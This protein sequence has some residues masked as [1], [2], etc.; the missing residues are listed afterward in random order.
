M[1]LYDFVYILAVILLFPFWGKYFLKK[2]Y[3][4]LLKHRL[5][6]DIESSQKKRIWVH[7]VSVGEVKSL[8]NFL[9]EVKKKYPGDDIVLSVTTPSGYAVARE[10]YVSLGILVINSPLD[11]SFT[12]RRFLKKINPRILVLNELEIWPNWIAVT[13]KKKVPIILINGRMSEIAFKRY[14]RVNFFLKRFFKRIDRF[15]VQAEI[16]K[17]RFSQLNI[18]LGKIKICGNIKA[19]E[20]VKGLERMPGEKNIFAELGIKRPDRSRKKILAVASSH[21][22]DEQLLVPLLPSL[23]KSFFVIIVPRHLDRVPNIEAHLAR[24]GVEPVTWSKRS[25]PGTGIGA[26][27]DKPPPISTNQSRVMIFDRMGYLFQ[28]LKISDLVFMGGTMERKI[29][30]HNL[31]EPAVLGK[32]I[33]GGP[34]FNNFPAIGEE[35]VSKGIYHVVHDGAELKKYLDEFGK[36]DIEHIRAEAVRCVSQQ[37]GSIYFI[38]DEM[39]QWTR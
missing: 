3:R 15:M 12:I 36:L 1:L 37:I 23:L 31:Y 2:E 26:A 19:D 25:T 34:C 9:H 28:V 10:E 17:D 38:L 29:G 32:P 11:F 13:H 20:A 14:R 18:P 27:A 30:G 4:V 7:A 39:A 5:S 35:L 21:A 33:T 8:K 16:Y 22:G 6:P 24:S